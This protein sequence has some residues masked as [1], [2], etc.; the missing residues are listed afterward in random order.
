[1]T[2]PKEARDAIARTVGRL[3]SLFEEEF[4]DQAKGR[5]GLHTE[6]RRGADARKTAEPG[7]TED[8]RLLLSW[9]EPIAALSLTPSQSTQ[10]SELLG[11]LSY[12]R[13]EGLD[14]GE[15]VRRLI[16]EA[17][18]TSVNRL[19]AVRVGESVGVF[20]EATAAGRQSRS[21]REVAQDLFPLLAQEED[22]GYWRYLQV[23]GDE[24]GASVPLLFDRRLPI[25]AFVPSRTCIDR[26]LDLLNDP[27]VVD[28]WVEPE[29]LGWAYQFFNRDDARKMR[30]ESPN[31]PR[32]SREL[33]VRNQFFTP[34]YVVDW[35]VQNTLG[36]RLRQADYDLALPLLVGDTEDAVPLSLEDVEILDP[37][38]G[39]GHFLLGCYDLLEQAWLS[40][41]VTS[42]EAAPRILRSLYGI[43]I[44]PRASQVAQVVLLLR[45]RRSAPVESVDA[46]TIV[47]ARPLPGAPD[48]RR[49]A[50]EEL[51]ANARDLAEGIDKA[52]V[53]APVL[54]S[55][56]KAEEAPALALM[57]TLRAPKLAIDV[58]AELLEQELLTAAAKIARDAD[59]SPAARM[60]SADTRDT[61]RL[62]RLFQQRYDIVL[63]NPPFGESVPEADAYLERHYPDSHSNLYCC[64]VDRAI[65][66]VDSDGY[67]GAITD[68]SG[69][70]IRSLE[71]WRTNSVVPRLRALLD[72]GRGVMH[73]AMVEAAAYVL[74]GGT[75]GKTSRRASFIRVIGARSLEAAVYSGG[76]DR[77]VRSV[78]RVQRIDGS[79]VAYWLPDALLDLFRG[80]AD[81]SGATLDARRGAYSG[82]D[83]R[84]I[85]TWWEVPGSGP[86]GES[87]R[88]ISFAKGGPYS[89]YFGDLLL[90]IDWDYERRTFTDF[91]GRPGRSSEIPENRDYFGRPGLTWSYKSDTGFAVRP[92]PR[93]SIFSHVGPMIFVDGDDEALLD[94]TMA[95]LNSTV[96]SALVEPLVTFGK[97]HAGAIQKV[98]NYRP[99][100]EAAALARRIAQVRMSEA[101]SDETSHFFV[102]PWRSRGGSNMAELGQQLDDAVAE[103][104]GVD[105]ESARPL[106]AK[107][108]TQWLAARARR[109]SAPTVH[110]QMS[111]LVGVVLGRWDI[112]IAN[113][114][115]VVKPELNPYAPLRAASPGMLLE[116]TPSSEEGLDYPLRIPPVPV[117]VDEPGHDADVVAALEG[118]A[119]ALK[120]GPDFPALTAFR[121]VPDLRRYLRTRFFREH[122]KTYS[123]SRRY[124][125]IYWYL[126][127][128]SKEWGVWA[129]ASALSREMLFALAG[130][131]RDRLRRLQEHL[132]QLERSAGDASARADTQRR[133]KLEAL[134]AELEHFLE[135]AE[136]VAQ[137]GWLPDLN[138]GLVLCATPLE[139]LFPDDAWR[140][141]V[142][143]HR[144]KL[145]KGEYPWA[146]VQHDYF[147]VGT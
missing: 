74:A 137:S 106:S 84:Y 57:N 27:D 130:S 9:V 38:C 25:S 4:F 136:G 146:S 125:P 21:Y 48:V 10:R 44:D 68:R 52:M 115:R 126:A 55:L 90:C 76:G 147:K 72:L 23:A 30:E 144:R 134:A 104:L 89:P 80:D 133:E 127:V 12:L 31:F 142:G 49:A 112:R 16:R 93:G 111:Y 13:R 20:P 67:V 60:F 56:L 129:Y 86:L 14:G 117:L 15:A 98:P 33:A 24:L 139:P 53:G 18:F 138:D 45:A 77:Y 91:H 109:H 69:L 79:P 128:P 82:D 59:A 11:A 141:E 83:F 102:S 19:L 66:L 108:T 85:R 1:L 35:L 58:S 101:E 116:P 8:E 17:A 81:S 110:E 34:H 118:A 46:P 78:D 131:A 50:F 121:E 5:F 71:S 64:F 94:S 97:Y 124:A 62:L 42:A 75:S 73:S 119:E 105:S 103:S 39:S 29:A 135:T 107:C 87:K 54:G 145:E 143:A 6:R 113:G 51:S 99:G 40:R 32:N 65:E 92:V 100:G 63:M 7:D 114:L 61:I 22:E 3:R 47:T 41:S 95:Y 122:L 120:S 96:G 88:W 26:A 132:S 70:F 37:A 140:K 2:L 36:R 28:A 43:D 123:G